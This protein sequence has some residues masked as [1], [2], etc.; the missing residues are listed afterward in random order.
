[1]ECN[2]MKQAISINERIYSGA[3]EQP[4]E[5]DVVLPDYCPDV[6]K[7]LKCA[8]EPMISAAFLNGEKVLVEGTAVV[9]VFYLSENKAVRCSEQ[10]LPFSKSA[11]IKGAVPDA[12][13]RASGSLNYVNCRVVSPRRLDIR[14]A[15]SLQITVWGNHQEEIVADGSGQGLQM[16]QDAMEQ[17]NILH[18]GSSA[19]DLEESVELS[20]GKAP[21]A[22][23]LRWSA[24]PELM[25]YKVIVGKVILKGEISLRVLYVT[26]D[27]GLDQVESTLPLS[28]IV[29]VP[30][31]DESSQCSVQLKLLSGEVLP[32]GDADGETRV[33]DLNL[34]LGAQIM[35]FSVE[36][37]TVVTDCYSTLYK[38]RTMTKKMPVL[39][40]VTL[41]GDNHT[42]SQSVDPSEPVQ[43]ILDY[44]ASVEEVKVRTEEQSALVTA[45]VT[46]GILTQGEEAPGYLE[47]TIPVEHRHEFDRPTQDL[48]FEPEVCLQNLGLSLNGTGSLEIHGDLRIQGPAFQRKQ[49]ELLTDVLLD[50]EKGKDPQN[51]CGLIIY[52]GAKGESLWDIAKAYNTS[53]SAVME[54]NALEQD[55]LPQRT[56]LLIPVVSG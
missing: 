24:K 52:Y 10:K 47:Q 23:I 8:V 35:A 30:G 1:M 40:L 32:K 14:G 7:V 20:Y 44:W 31:A 28:Q 51:D 22:S 33:L 54:E 11:E 19:F 36:P 29:D 55:L 3:A 42:L 45:K 49:Q 27:G 37:L 34:Q 43:G 46:V 4:I 16:R 2:V 48:V 9:R 13:V 25:D 26:E 38:T 18:Q 56:M 17:V 15:L 50:Q 21:I 53:V 6:H 41:V 39:Q 5:C 12:Y